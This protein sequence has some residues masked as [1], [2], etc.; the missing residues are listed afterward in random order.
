MASESNRRLFG[1]PLNI[2]NVYGSRWET[3][4]GGFGSAKREQL[5]GFDR[6]EVSE[7]GN[8][9]R[10]V[11][12][13][14]RNHEDLSD[15][16]S[17]LLRPHQYRFICTNRCSSRWDRRGLEQR[18]GSDRRSWQQRGW[19][20]VGRRNAGLKRA[21]NEHGRRSWSNSTVDPK[22]EPNR[23]ISNSGAFDRLP[24]RRKPV[25][26]LR[27]QLQLKVMPIRPRLRQTN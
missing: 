9:S 24:G 18:G 22:P 13:K 16:L 10:I 14:E 17:Y 25:G 8:M 6:A 5:G 15:W 2:T 27:Q 20:D 23:K 4:A 11:R 19:F 26:I 12:A 3:I 21:A 7:P 1:V